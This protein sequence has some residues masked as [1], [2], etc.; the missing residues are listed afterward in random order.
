MHHGITHII[1]GS[2]LLGST[3]RQLRLAR[4]LGEAGSPPYHPAYLHHPLILKPNGEKLSKS[5]ADS[6]VR[7][8]RRAGM[9][10]A[11]VIAFASAADGLAQ[12]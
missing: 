1:R 8:L 3:G 10:A 4:M 6:G 12:V 11:D 9:S 2:D 7:E 5:S